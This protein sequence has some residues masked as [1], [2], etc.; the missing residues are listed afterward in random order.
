M[1]TAPGAL[2]ALQEALPTSQFLF[3]GSSDYEDFNQLYRSAVN[4]DH[5]PKCIFLPLDVEE[6]STFV[7][8]IGDYVRRGTARFAIVGNGNQI[9]PG[10]NNT[11][12]IAGSGVD[13]ITVNLSYMAGVEIYTGLHT[14]LYTGLV[15]ISAGEAWEHIYSILNEK[16][17]AVAGPR[18]GWAG[19]IGG[20]PLFY[21]RHGF[22]CD[23][24]VNFEVVLA[25]GDIVNANEENHADLWRALRGG[26][27]NFGIVTRFDMLTYKQRDVFGA[28]FEYE[29]ADFPGQ[30]QALVDQLTAAHPSKNLHTTLCM[31]FE[32]E[33]RV[34]CHNHIYINAPITNLP[35]V[36]EPFFPVT[37]TRGDRMSFLKATTVQCGGPRER[38]ASMNTTLR[39]D[40]QILNDATNI[41]EE[42]LR[43]AYTAFLHPDNET[44]FRL[45][46]RPLTRHMLEASASKGGNS[47]GLSPALGPLVSVC[48]EANWLHDYGD[49]PANVTLENIINRIRARALELRQA[50]TFVDSS[51]AHWSQYPIAVEC[52]GAL[53]AVSRKYDPEGLF[54]KAVP[55]GFKLWD[56]INVLLE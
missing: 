30:I 34:E 24:I 55:G 52:V 15:C 17:L 44:K 2:E 39:A 42:A 29:H 43:E 27:N 47:L 31:C 35:A 54:Q 9:L 21:S 3:P 48:L 45:T 49:Y 23:N 13:S 12:Q 10:S 32:E 56:A 40:F 46:L 53:Q 5:R 11:H 14:G 26:G 33:G 50:A 20:I 18:T 19:K 6:I 22:V 28:S 37:F 16:G 36:M 38:R 41:C 4:A 25:S 1:A 51:S 8:V 7:K